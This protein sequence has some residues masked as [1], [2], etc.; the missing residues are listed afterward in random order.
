VE[1]SAYGRLLERSGN[2]SAT[3]VPQGVYRSADVDADGRQ[4]RWVAISVADDVQWRALCRV[5]DRRD[6]ADDPS[7]GSARGR[8][9]VE[10]ELDRELAVWCGSRPTGAIVESLSAAGVPAEPVVP[11]HEHDGL[12]QVQWRRLFE[13]VEHPIVGT[14]DFIGAPFRLANGPQIHNRRH[15]PLLGEHNRD[16]L[17]RILGLSDDDVDALGADGVIGDTVVGGVLH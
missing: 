10:D 16:V 1:H 8:R 11:A 14:V 13:P 7:L 15:A 4:D 9:A 6:W 3:Y 12:A 2:R 17:T 5:V